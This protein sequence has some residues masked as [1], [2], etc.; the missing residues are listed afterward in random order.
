MLAITETHLHKH[1]END[2][3]EIEGYS[4][5]RKDRQNSENSWGS[6]LVYIAEDLDAFEREDLNKQFTVEVVWIDIIIASQ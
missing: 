3:L 6:C 1:I 2:Q 5:A 4:I